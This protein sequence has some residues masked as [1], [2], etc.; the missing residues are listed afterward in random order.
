MVISC[1]IVD[2]TSTAFPWTAKLVYSSTCHERTPSGPAKVSV[3]CRWP[4]IRGNLTLK[5]VGTLI[6]W[7][8]KAG[9]RSRRGP[10]MITWSSSMRIQNRLLLWSAISP[11]RF[12]SYI[13]AC[14]QCLVWRSKISS[15]C[16]RMYRVNQYCS[17]LGFFRLNVDANKMPTAAS[18]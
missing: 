9:G 17:R 14:E 16:A 10:Y 7:P 5:C 2:Q 12:A 4:L 13:T 15:A 18:C 6:T 11:L 8:Y 3:H 1:L